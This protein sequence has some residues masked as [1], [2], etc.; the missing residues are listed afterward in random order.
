MEAEEEYRRKERIALVLIVAVASV[1]VSS[2]LVAFSYYCYIR[3][4]VSKRLQS[5]P[6]SHFYSLPFF[7]FNFLCYLPAEHNELLFLLEYV[8]TFSQYPNRMLVFCFLIRACLSSFAASHFPFSLPSVCLLRTCAPRF[9]EISI[10]KLSCI[11]WHSSGQCL[12]LCCFGCLG[13][14]RK[15]KSS[16][17]ILVS[18]KIV[19]N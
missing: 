10:E 3:N 15:K 11:I 5:E 14:C 13:N 19:G 12:S 9:G 1:A 7:P 8:L 16:F 2:L 6:H 17:E 4:K 18:E